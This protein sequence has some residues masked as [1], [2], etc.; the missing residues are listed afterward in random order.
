MHVT[1][2]LRWCLSF[3]YDKYLLIPDVSLLYAKLYL[4]DEKHVVWL[5]SLDP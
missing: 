3:Q 2:H 4:S 5:P 1:R